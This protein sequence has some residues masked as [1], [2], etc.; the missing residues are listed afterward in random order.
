MLDVENEEVRAKLA[1]WA[2]EN[3]VIDCVVIYGSYA[4]GTADEESDL[5]LMVAS[6]AVD[7]AD[8]IERA[9]AWKEQLQ[10][11]LCFQNVSLYHYSPGE[12]RTMGFVKDCHIVVYDRRGRL[13]E[14]L[15]QVARS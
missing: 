6:Q 15:A 14:I 10:R 8:E 13:D 5:D 7:L 12:S 2:A 9:A 4:K 11:M 3:P 1:R